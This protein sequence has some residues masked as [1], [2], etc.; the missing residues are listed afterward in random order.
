MICCYSITNIF[1][2][3]AHYS[4]ILLDAFRCEH[5]VHFH[6]FHLFFFSLNIFVFMPAPAPMYNQPVFF[7]LPTLNIVVS[8]IGRLA[9]SNVN[10]FC[11]TE[12]SMVELSWC[13]RKSNES[14]FLFSQ[15]LFFFFF[16]FFSLSFFNVSFDKMK[17]CRTNWMLVF[18]YCW[19]TILFWSKF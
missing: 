3:G 14:V 1:G 5:L 15:W 13:V 9:C 11:F 16:G 6:V 4:P 10:Q 18:E 17:I 7:L 2:S 8:E 12:L 19:P